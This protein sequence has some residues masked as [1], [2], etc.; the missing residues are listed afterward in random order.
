MN[1]YGTAREQAAGMLD[2]TITSNARRSRMRPQLIVLCVFTSVGI[3]ACSDGPTPPHRAPRRPSLVIVSGDSQTADAGTALPQ[4]VVLKLTD[5]LG[6]PAVHHLITSY[7]AGRVLEDSTFTDAQGIASLHWILGGYA[8]RQSLTA[9]AFPY[10]DFSYGVAYATIHATAIAG[11]PALITR[12]GDSAVVTPGTDLDTLVITL[13]DR[14]GNAVGQVPATWS[15]TAGG[16]SVVALSAKTDATGSARAIWTVGPSLG[17]NAL[18]VTAAGFTAHFLAT[19]TGPLTALAVVAGDDDSCALKSPGATYCWGAISGHRKVPVRL[20]GDVVFA[21]LVAGSHHMCGLTGAGEAYCWGANAAGQ[22]GSDPATPYQAAPVRVDGRLFFT[23]L[24]AGGDHTC[25]LTSA[26]SVFCWGDNSLGQL[27]DASFN[28]H[29]SPTRV[30]GTSSFVAIAAGSSFT[31]GLGTAGE[32]YC[33]GDNAQSQLSVEVSGQCNQGYDYYYGP[34]YTECSSTPVRV[35]S[36]PALTTLAASGPGSCGLTTSAKLM[37]WGTGASDPQT[38]Q[39]GPF[40]SMAVGD[41]VCGLD[42]SAAVSCWRFG[43]GG[44]SPVQLLQPATLPFASLTGSATHFC[45]LARGTPAIVYCWGD[46]RRGQLGDGT[47]LMRGAAVAVVAPI[48]P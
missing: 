46:N 29:A 21:S 43:A 45:G 7:G 5:S 25:G 4:P 42:A 18:D 3:A 32:T 8:S 19:A 6:A 22:L 9:Q 20:A 34:I 12:K 10:P 14:F 24:A 23:M 27:G 1:A 41:G 13:S 11:P 36:L 17:A 30:A 26:G 40:T 33:W 44:A 15:V 16:G 39:A 28:S 31:C 48:E 2:G 38:I 37:C 35:T 47:T